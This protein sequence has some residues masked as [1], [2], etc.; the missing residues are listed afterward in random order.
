[1]GG[2]TRPS[3]TINDERKARKEKQCTHE[4]REGVD[5]VP[6]A[7][8]RFESILDPLLAVFVVEGVGF[9]QVE[10]VL[11]GGVLVEEFGVAG[12]EHRE[13]VIAL[14]VAVEDQPGRLCAE[15]LAQ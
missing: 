11:F 8:H 2:G 4:S 14:R 15:C 6:Q 9:A 13:I 1:M 10:A 7:D 12:D 3:Q 5:L